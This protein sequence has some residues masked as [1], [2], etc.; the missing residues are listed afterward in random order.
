MLD[1]EFSCLLS[2]S[3]HASLIRDNALEISRLVVA[4]HLRTRAAIA[5]SR[6]RSTPH[7]VELLLKALY[8]LSREQGIEHYYMVVETTWLK[9]FTR[10]FHLPLIPIGSPYTFPDGTE[11]IAVYASLTHMEEHIKLHDP[12]RYHWYQER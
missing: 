8:Q 2:A 11:T 10:R 4:P 6:E 5:Q 12:R 9:P 7:P 1:R 3:E